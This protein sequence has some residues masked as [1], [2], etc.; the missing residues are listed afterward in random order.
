MYV[1]AEIHGRTYSASTVADPGAIADPL[2]GGP[3]PCLLWDHD[4]RSPAPLRSAVARALLEAGCRYVVCGGH[5]C[6]AWHDAIDWEFVNAHIDDP[7]G[8]TDAA[9]VMTSW[10][11]GQTP[12]DV[13][14]FFVRNT[15]FD[16]HDFRTHVV[17]HVGAGS[18][19]D[20]LNAAVRRHALAEGAA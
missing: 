12:D 20:R 2:P 7:T 8:V 6:E 5:N 13:A 19:H 15:N 10:H 14:F 11:D 1:I 17:L 16:D 9:H 3:F 4:G 18:D